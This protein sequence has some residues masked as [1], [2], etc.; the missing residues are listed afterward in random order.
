MD[1]KPPMYDFVMAKLRSRRLPQRKVAAESG[2]P[3]STLTKIAQGQIKEPS[4]HS[5]QK[6]HDYFV[7][8][9]AGDTVPEPHQE[10]A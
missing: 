9:G 3:F 10:A 5:I 2:V 4:V 6:L 8:V 7:K 1:T